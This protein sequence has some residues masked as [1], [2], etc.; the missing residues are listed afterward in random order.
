MKVL[1]VISDSNIG[2]AGVLLSTLLRNFDKRRVQSSVA[3]PRKSA[4]CRRLEELKIP[5]YPLA[6]T[7]DRLSPASI[8]EIHTI[9]TQEGIDLIHANAALAARVAGRLSHIPVVH[10]RH[11]CYPPRGIWKIPPVRYLGGAC[12]R[13]LSDLVI[14]TADA[15]AENLRALGIRDESI[16]VI[17]N[18]SEAVRAVEDAE[19]AVMRVRYGIEE[20]DFTVGICARLEACK[21]H[22]AFL[23]AAK[24]VRERMPQLRFR[25]L[26]VGTGSLERMLKR[27]VM[28]LGLADSV[29]F[30]GFVEDMAPIYRLLRVNV[31]CSCGTETS[32][33]AISEGMSASLPTV[34]SDYGG[35]R[36]MLGESE[37]GILFPVGDAEALAEAICAIAGDRER[38]ARMKKAAYERYLNCF[39][40]K[41]MTSRVTA[42]YE[43]LLRSR[44]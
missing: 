20:D 31:N 38:E 8:H 41:E 2:G 34:A 26:I 4:L 43:R 35:N 13:M 28:E 25:F 27:H 7:C 32:C 16:E 30:L 33:L 42:L 24:L 19:L 5:M 10:T 9:A 3:L 36:A 14:A 29:R 44:N 39:T 40:P 37:G 22:G 15:A 6:H 12:N 11:C 17:I 23:R 1:H 18:G 21:G